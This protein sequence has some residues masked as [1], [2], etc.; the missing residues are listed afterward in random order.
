MAG[1]SFVF[2]VLKDLLRNQSDFRGI[3][4]RFG[5]RCIFVTHRGRHVYFRHVFATIQQLL[6]RIKNGFLRCEYCSALKNGRES[7]RFD[8]FGNDQSGQNKAAAI[9]AGKE[10]SGRWSR[11]RCR[12]EAVRGAKVL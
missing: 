6:R 4:L 7:S 3:S 5:S 8:H 10:A 1:K 2:F 9:E 11:G 12:R